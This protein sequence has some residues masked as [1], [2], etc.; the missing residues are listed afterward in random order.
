MRSRSRSRRSKP[1]KVFSGIGSFPLLDPD[2]I[3]A[4]TA[5]GKATVHGPES[6][7][8]VVTQLEASLKANVGVALTD[9]EQELTGP[10]AWERVEA[11]AKSLVAG[12]VSSGVRVGIEMDRTIDAVVAIY[13]VLAAG[14]SYVPLDPSQPENRRQ[15]LITRAGC[16][17]VI[18]EIPTPTDGSESLELPTVSLEDE[19]YLLFTSGSTGEPKGVP[20]THLGLADYLAYAND[21]YVGEAAP[22]ASLI[23]HLTFDLTVTSLFMP[24]SI[25]MFR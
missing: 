13:A 11:L 1:S 9:G 7:T 25:P 21:A 16:A 17:I 12:G 8:D 3:S 6:P 4:V 14:G 2:E 20:I 22:V 24:D 5:W 10:D 18:R 19:A 23:Q 15:Q